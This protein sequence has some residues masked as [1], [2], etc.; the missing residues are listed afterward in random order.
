[1]VCPQCGKKVIEK[2]GTCYEK[3][4]LTPLRRKI[5]KKLGFGFNFY[6]KHKCKKVFIA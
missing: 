6:V 3:E 4:A 5:Q 1:M 2:C